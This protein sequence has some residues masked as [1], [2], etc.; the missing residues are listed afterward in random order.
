MSL[1]VA[2]PGGSRPLLAFVLA[3]AALPLLAAPGPSSRP[4]PLLAVAAQAE[5][6]GGLTS[7]ADRGSLPRGAL[8]AAASISL[9]GETW[10]WISLGL[11]VFRAE[12]SLPDAS[13][14]L[15]RGYEGS[16]LFL[17]TG[18]RLSLSGLGLPFLAKSRAEILAGPGLLVAE[19]TGTTLVSLLPFLRLDARVLSPLSRG[20]SWSL[21]LPLL[22]ER[23][24]AVWSYYGGLSLGFS[25]SPSP[26][27]S[28]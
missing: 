24:A 14:F 11:E 6:F 21:G 7:S 12:P 23:H 17:Q 18:P 8:G 28:K 25:W 9:G 13:L 19:D 20:W 2:C 3:L 15:Y 22:V 16:S 26:R 27:R 4:G 1:R 10:T 5:G